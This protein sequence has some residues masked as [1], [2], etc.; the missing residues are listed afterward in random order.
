MIN[1][2]A[3]WKCG[4]NLTKSWRSAP[5]FQDSH[6]YN[7]DNNYTVEVDYGNPLNPNDTTI[8]HLGMNSHGYTVEFVTSTHGNRLALANNY[9]IG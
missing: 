9:S 6:Y 2:R 4:S 5:S 1:S 3:S 8:G 7:K